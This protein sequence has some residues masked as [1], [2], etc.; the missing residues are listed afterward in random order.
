MLRDIRYSQLYLANNSESGSGKRKAGL[1]VAL[2]GTFV[3]LCDG[4]RVAEDK[5]G[6][7]LVVVFAVGNTRG[8]EEVVILVSVAWR[9]ESD[10]AEL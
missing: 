4:S 3:Q 10:A 9:E 2:D 6:R 7:L 1:S 5:D 8:V